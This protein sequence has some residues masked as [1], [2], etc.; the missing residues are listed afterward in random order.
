MKPAISDANKTIAKTV[1][2]AFGGSPII[3]RFWDDQHK[4]HVDI[5]KCEESPVGGVDSYSTVGLSDWPLYQGE[6]EYGVRLELVAACGCTFANFDLA[7]STA[8]FCIINSRWFCFPGAI[9]RYV[10]A[11]YDCSP[12]MRHFLF[13]PPFLL[14]NDLN[15]IDLV[16]KKV[17][18]LLAIPISEAERQFA[19][20]NG[21]D[22]LE[23]LFVASRIDIFNLHRPS[24]I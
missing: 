19:V 1:A 18:W 7:L 16:E 6:A 17:V 23:N 15:T 4:S 13:V 21:S 8:A 10:L 22:E 12:T 20:E 14:E 9:F 5:L 24:E 2:A 11:M 3:T